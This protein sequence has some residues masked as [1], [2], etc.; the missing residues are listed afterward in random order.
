MTVKPRMLI[1]AS[2]RERNSMR[3]KRILLSMALC[4]VMGLFC[5]SG[6]GAEEGKAFCA[7]ARGKLSGNCGI[8]SPME[9]RA[10]SWWG[11]LC[12][13]ALFLARAEDGEA[14]AEEVEFIWPIWDWLL[15]LLGLN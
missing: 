5:V 4:F 6:A 7:K 1:A 15:A 3:G 9:G 8:V 12:D 10:K 14:E 2:R 11:L 13:D